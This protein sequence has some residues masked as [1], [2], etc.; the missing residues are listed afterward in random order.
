[1]THEDWS[2]AVPNEPLLAESRRHRVQHDG[3][4]TE[5]R[6]AIP[7]PYSHRAIVGISAALCLTLVLGAGS[8]GAFSVV[9]TRTVEDILCQQH[10]GRVV[11]GGPEEP[12]DE[13]M[14]KIESIQK[15]LAF[16]FAATATVR[17]LTGTSEVGRVATE[18][19]NDAQGSS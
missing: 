13:Q 17:S 15:D 18:Q 7:Q 2:D 16:I 4:V 10:Y 14:C 9:A 6:P 3:H 8:W 11:V 1:M 12:I 19:T 5:E